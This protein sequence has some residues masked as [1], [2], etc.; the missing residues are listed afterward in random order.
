[1]ET[2][3]SVP[4]ALPLVFAWLTSLELIVARFVCKKWLETCRRI[5]V[6]CSLRPIELVSNPKPI[7]ADWALEYFDAPPIRIQR[8][9]CAAAAS[10]GE[11]CLLHF[12]RYPLDWDPRECAIAAARRGNVECLIA[13]EAEENRRDILRSCT[14]ATRWST[15][16]AQFSWAGVCCCIAARAGHLAVLQHF[17]TTSWPYYPGHQDLRIALIEAAM[18][19]KQLAVLD[20]LGSSKRPHIH[21]VE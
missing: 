16:P 7:L 10:S 5:G 21:E 1:M 6:S 8:Q 14:R 18:D 19:G 12:V 2:L 3:Y 17:V 4:E 9:I 20:W 11:S 15:P 13:I